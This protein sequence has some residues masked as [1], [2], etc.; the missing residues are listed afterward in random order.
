MRMNHQTSLHNPLGAF[1][2]SKATRGLVLVDPL[3]W[4]EL[5][6]CDCWV[7]KTAAVVDG[8]IGL[9][10]TL[11]EWMRLDCGEIDDDIDNIGEHTSK[12]LAAH[13]ILVTLLT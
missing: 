5:L 13:H 7:K 6:P 9:S 11:D 1:V 2:L 3:A 8:I 10:L 12:L 4:M